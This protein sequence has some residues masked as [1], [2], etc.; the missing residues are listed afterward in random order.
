MEF[1]FWFNGI[2]YFGQQEH[3]VKTVVYKII[4]FL[5]LIHDNVSIY[6][7]IYMYIKKKVFLPVL[8][9]FG[10]CKSQC[11]Q[12]LHGIPFRPGEGQDGVG[13]PERAGWGGAH[14]FLKNRRKFSDF[15]KIL[16][17]FLRFLQYP[18]PA[19]NSARCPWIKSRELR[20]HDF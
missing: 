18:P 14:Q 2:I 7:Y 12:T 6:I 1:W 16:E 15:S 5:W 10:P 3:L 11:N 9:A 8:Y 17:N 4:V 13:A 20:D 19:F